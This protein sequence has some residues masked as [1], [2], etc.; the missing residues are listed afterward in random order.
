MRSKSRKP[1][2]FTEDQKKRIVAK[3]VHVPVATVCQEFNIS[4]STFYRWRLRFAQPKS[5][6]GTRLHDL[7][8]EN[9]RLKRQV[10][11]LWLDYTSL[12]NA[13][14]NGMGREC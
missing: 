9:R 1:V 10:A 12:R 8:S 2:R 11:E 6:E 13:L 4:L 5:Q 3:G 14:I 7:E